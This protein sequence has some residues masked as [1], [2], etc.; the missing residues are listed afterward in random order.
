MK[1]IYWIEHLVCSVKRLV[2][3]I[4][5]SKLKTLTLNVVFKS[6]VKIISTKI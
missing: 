1:K 5:E 4:F 6:K 3:I 2:K